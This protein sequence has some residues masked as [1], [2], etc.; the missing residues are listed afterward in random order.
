MV[1]FRDYN[2]INRE[3]KDFQFFEKEKRSNRWISSLWLKSTNVMFRNLSFD[4]YFIKA[5]HHMFYVK[6]TRIKF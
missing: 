6:N 2:G 4:K 1:N 3:N 5:V